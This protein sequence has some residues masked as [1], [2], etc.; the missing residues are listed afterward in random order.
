MILNRVDVI[1]GAAMLASPP[2]F[3]D[4]WNKKTFLTFSQPVEVPGV[5]LPAGNYVFKLADSPSNRHIVQIF[6][7]EEDLVYATILAIPHHR[8]EPAEETVILF[9]ERRADQPQAIHAW[10]YPGELIGQQFVY[11]KSRALELARVTHQ[12]VPSGEVRPDEARAELESAPLVEVTPEN[13]KVEP[14]EISE[15]TPVATPAPSTEPLTP[16]PRETPTAQPQPELPKTA[17]PIPLIGLLGASG[18]GLA[19]LLKVFR[20]RTF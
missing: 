4:A 10:F 12:P 19:G 13:E 2:A 7:A 6:N 16:A 1:L 14:V 11:P 5:I 17:S 15:P 18:L 9:E 20:M 3:G 8:M